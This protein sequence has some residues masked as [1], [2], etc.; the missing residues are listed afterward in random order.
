MATVQLLTA[1]P[2]AVCTSVSRTVPHSWP[3]AS[4]AAGCKT[5][6][7]PSIAVL[8]YTF[9]YYATL[10][11]G[12]TNCLL[13]HWRCRVSLIPPLLYSASFYFYSCHSWHSFNLFDYHS[14]PIRTG[15]RAADSRLLRWH[16]EED[17]PGNS[18][19]L[20]RGFPDISPGIPGS[21][22]PAHPR[23]FPEIFP[24]NPWNCW[25]I[26]RTIPGIGG[27]SRQLHRKCIPEHSQCNL[28]RNSQVILPRRLTGNLPGHSPGNFPVNSWG[29]PGISCLEIP[30]R[31]LGNPRT[32]SRM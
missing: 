9:L 20:P 17:L 14:R 16:L 8:H 13:D 28:Q 29:I 26:P 5:L 4:S 27:H 18:R 32:L 1:S 31:F 19:E 2:T 21:S 12:Y 25:E 3:A 23:T 24:G 7:S 15:R 22:P 11:Q 10:Y 6:S 30:G